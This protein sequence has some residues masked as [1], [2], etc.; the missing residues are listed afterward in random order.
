MTYPLP[1]CRGLLREPRV[2]MHPFLSLSSPSPSSK[3][4]RHPNP[5][6]PHRLPQV[7]PSGLR[8]E[9]AARG[10]RLSPPWGPLAPLG[11][12]T[13]SGV[14]GRGGRRGPAPSARTPPLPPPPPPRALPGAGLWAGEWGSKQGKDGGGGQAVTCQPRH[15]TRHRPAPPPLVRPAPRFAPPHWPAAQP[16]GNCLQGLLPPRDK[17]KNGRLA[18]L[19]LLQLLSLSRSK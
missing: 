9:G 4:G 11:L 17:A 10:L 15:A 16:M 13:A 7:P 5:D 2:R 3:P 14:R 12:G 1:P 6:R 18:A 19:A 8:G